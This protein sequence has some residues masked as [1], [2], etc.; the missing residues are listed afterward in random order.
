MLKRLKAMYDHSILD[1]NVEE[2]WDH[3]YFYN[4]LTLMNNYFS[5][6]IEPQTFKGCY[7]REFGRLE[8]H[9]GSMVDV[10]PN[11]RFF[12]DYSLFPDLPSL[13]DFRYQNKANI[14]T[15]QR[16]F[17]SNYLEIDFM[18]FDTVGK[19]QSIM[20]MDLF[21]SVHT[22][23]EDFYEENGMNFVYKK[24]EDEC[25]LTPNKELLKGPDHVVISQ[26]IYE[27]TGILK[28][29]GV[30]DLDTLISFVLMMGI[31]KNKLSRTN[32]N[33]N[34]PETPITSWQAFRDLEHIMRNKYVN[35]YDFKNDRRWEG[36]DRDQFYRELKP[37]NQP[38]S[39]PE[40]IFFFDNIINYVWKHKIKLRE[41]VLDGNLEIT[42][43]HFPDYE[44]KMDM[45]QL[46]EK[47]NI[48]IVIE[49]FTEVLGEDY[50]VVENLE[51]E[52]DSDF[53]FV[54][55][56]RSEISTRTGFDKEKQILINVMEKKR[57]SEEQYQDLEEHDQSVLHIG[58]FMFRLRPGNKYPQFGTFKDIEDLWYNFEFL[59]C[60]RYYMS[61]F[62]EKQKFF[63]TLS[64]EEF[65]P[66]IE[67]LKSFSYFIEHIQKFKKP[68]QS[69]DDAIPGI[70]D[71]YYY[72]TYI[73]N[74]FF[75]FQS[76]DFKTHSEVS[77]LLKLNDDK[78]NPT[79]QDK[80]F[81]IQPSLTQKVLNLFL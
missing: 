76:I 67:I 23:M 58:L 46:I 42:D 24:D 5:E 17:I 33:I 40:E 51:E 26:R 48:D 27:Y 56:Q 69:Q 21:F 37:F 63:F 59:F 2:V 57:V 49:Y 32:A 55:D 15:Q 22:Q 25:K 43:E 35:S 44:S 34:H 66:I 12:W 60:I 14:R 68:D 64:Q 28:T 52:S 70:Y 13:A 30:N 19:A 6:E 45:Q 79:N 18:N 39:Y 8:F 61:I 11:N 7:L 36:L 81:D 10:A 74:P 4:H 50:T 72:D 75:Y 80:S 78:N 73:Q 1:Q 29:E 54:I 53:Q 20:I 9:T 62:A 38:Y 65:K 16:I 31:Y 71:A 3:D 47:N 41:A 77:R